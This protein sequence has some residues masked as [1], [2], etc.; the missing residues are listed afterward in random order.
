MKK[1]FFLVLF[2]SAATI[3]MG[4]SN[5]FLIYSMKGNITS[6]DNKVESKVKIG[7]LLGVNNTIKVP[8]GGTVTLILTEQLYRACTILKNEKYHH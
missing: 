7:K 2:V 8:A 6:I 3:M 5:S 4:Q 1:L